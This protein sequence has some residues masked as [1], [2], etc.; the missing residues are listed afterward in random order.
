MGWNQIGARTQV[1]TIKPIVW[2]EG[3]EKS[4]SQCAVDFLFHRNGKYDGN[5]M[6]AF[7][8]CSH[9]HAKTK[10][11]WT[12]RKRS[13]YFFHMWM[14]LLLFVCL[15]VEPLCFLLFLLFR[16][17]FWSNEIHTLTHFVE[18][19]N[20]YICPFAYLYCCYCCYFYYW[21]SLSKRRKTATTTD[22]WCTMK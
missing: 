18:S 7:L 9:I 16:S 11:S 19:F 22:M 5:E 12:K 4:V 20:A 2:A 14:W 21:L 13:G 17:L 8:L 10:L 6:D 15:F 3:K 1:I